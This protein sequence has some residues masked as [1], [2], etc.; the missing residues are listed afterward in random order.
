MGKDIHDTDITDAKVIDSTGN[1]VTDADYSFEPVPVTA[2]KG[3]LSF[4]VV[5]L[6]FT[7]N[8]ASMN[9]GARIG[10]SADFANFIYA[11]LLGGLF[12][13]L[14]TGALAYIGCR[15]GMSFDQ[16][17]R[18]SFGSQGSKIPSF[19]ISV[20][21]VGWF[22]VCSAMFALPVAD[23]LNCSPYVVIIIAGICMTSS[24]Y[25]GFKGLEVISFIAVP[26]IIIL[27]GWSVYLAMSGFGSIQDI[28]GNNTGEY[29]L[30]A[31]VGLV[32]GSFIS[33]GC[34][35][36]NFARFANTK[37]NAV[38]CT[39]T[40]F[41]I[42][43]SLMLIF[44]AVGSAVT[45]K[46]DIFYSMMSQGLVLSAFVVLG[47]NIWTTNDNAL[48]TAGL[49]L[50]NIFSI[51]K[52]L[53]VLA[54]GTVGTICAFWIYEHFVGWLTVLSATLPAVGIIMILDYFVYPEKYRDG[55]DNKK[56]HLSAVAGTIAGMLMGNLVGYGSPGINSIVT[57]AT[58]WFIFKFFERKRTSV[59]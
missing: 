28:F 56:W 12:L 18:R 1:K 35:T 58:V 27:G 11:L 49:G 34:S 8:S 45:G 17:T 42:G 57:G 54:G 55:G 20:T 44:G 6:G 30:N 16:L 21:Q 31:L 36:P 33:G 29:D 46:N 41:L 52:K 22:G 26:L 32:I 23:Y 3:V 25:V 10:V 4:L 19:F 13:A 53:M 15:T 50:S 7:F 14:F 5:M 43:N 37:I 24:A 51:R 40:A 2:R 39:V 38:V 9:V 48:Y 47:A 59:R